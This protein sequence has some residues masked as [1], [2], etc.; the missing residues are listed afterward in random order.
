MRIPL[1]IRV[2]VRGKLTTGPKPGTPE[3][4]AE[5]LARAAGLPADAPQTP[6]VAVDLED[7]VQ[8]PAIPE[9]SG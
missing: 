5:Q 1:H 4:E 8:P 7:E 6:L 2:Q 9:S 3:F